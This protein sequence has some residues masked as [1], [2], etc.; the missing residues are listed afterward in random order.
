MPS[1]P[2]CATTVALLPSGSRLP[3][4]LPLPEHMGPVLVVA[5]AVALAVVGV[6][7]AVA[8]RHRLAPSS[9]DEVDL[10]GADAPRRPRAVAVVN[11]TKLDAHAGVRQALEDECRRRGWRRPLWWETTVEDNGAGPAARAV[12]EGADLVLV[13]GG[14]GTVRA[15]LPALAGT[16]V[17]VALVPAGTGNLLARN[18]GVP[19]GDHGAALAVAFDG[20]DRPVDLARGTVKLHP[21]DD[22]APP[23]AQVQHADFLVMAGLGFDAE[24]MAAVEPG[25]KRTVGWWAYV[26]AG[27]G[28]LS[29]RDHRISIVIDGQP[30]RQRRVRS[31]IIGNCGSLTGGIRLLPEAVVDDG[32]LDLVVVAPRGVLGWAPVALHVLSGSRRGHR[33]VEHLRGRRIEL[34]TRTP[35]HLQLDGDAFGPATA[36]LAEAD[37]GA[38]LVRVPPQAG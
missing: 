31:A 8:V 34:R 33:R 28:K 13:V 9:D 21:G 35:L 1:A 2:T 5:V 36:L 25:L 24:V 3:L 27:V 29:G 19:V 26:V 15:A 22:K 11:P 10:P 32:M 6:T 37:P 12:R 14:D 4:L 18:L 38:V 16:G 17:P 20:V 30:P 23:G 7:A